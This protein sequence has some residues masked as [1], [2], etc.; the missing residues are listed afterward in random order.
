MQPGVQQ[1]VDD[2]AELGF[3]PVIEAELVVHTVIPV[4]G[5]LAGQLVQAGVGQDELTTWPQV[6]PHWIHLPATVGFRETNSQESPKSGWLMHSRQIEG[7]GDSAP[8]TGWASHL[9]AV[10]SEV[11]P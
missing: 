11:V 4:S 3:D 2:M 1:F 5:G 6:P 9:Q 10:L 7:W 8:N